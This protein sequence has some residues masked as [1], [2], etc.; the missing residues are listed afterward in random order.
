MRTVG[1]SIETTQAGD[2]AVIAA[3]LE[4]ARVVSSADSATSE[5]NA[6]PKRART[7][8]RCS[9]MTALFRCLN[10]GVDVAA[11]LREIQW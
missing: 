11:A 8:L 9:I 1:E 4:L 10:F 6:D 7:S 5:A 2:T 3:K